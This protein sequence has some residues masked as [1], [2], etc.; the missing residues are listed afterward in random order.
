MDSKYP[1]FE[2]E[3]DP[4]CFRQ[5][6]KIQLIIGGWCFWR[7]DKIILIIKGEQVLIKGTWVIYYYDRTHH[8]DMTRAQQSIWD[9][10]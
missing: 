3:H 7:E 1:Q 4:F 8:N 9:L 10:K 2:P 5:T 6:F